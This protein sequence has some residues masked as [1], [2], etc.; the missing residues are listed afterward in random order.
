MNQLNSLIIEGNV[1]RQAELSEP[2]AGFKVCKFPVA[3]D[4]WYKNRNGEG[5]SVGC[6][7]GFQYR[8]GTVGR[9]SHTRAEREKF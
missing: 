4:R 6:G 8:T 2:T 5:V 3:V 7:L 9:R 1:V